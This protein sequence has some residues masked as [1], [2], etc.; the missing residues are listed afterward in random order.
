MKDCS[1]EAKKLMEENRKNMTAIL[2]E[3]GSKKGNGVFGI[4][5]K[6]HGLVQSEKYVSGKYTVP[7]SSGWTVNRAI[8][9]WLRGG[10]END[11][12]VHL[13]LEPWPSNVGCA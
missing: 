9:E 12:N 11:N 3:I 1:E 13:G 5:C 2:T 4:G 6:L 10:E 7:T 8:G